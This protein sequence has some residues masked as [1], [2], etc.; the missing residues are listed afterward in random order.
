[1]HKPF[2]HVAGVRP[3]PGLFRLL[4]RYIIALSLGVHSEKKL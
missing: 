1:M 4:V 3:E 2:V